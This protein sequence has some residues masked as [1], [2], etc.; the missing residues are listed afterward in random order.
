V[1]LA[2]NSNSTSGNGVNVNAVDLGAAFLPQNQ[3]PT[4][5]PN[6]TPGADALPANVLRPIQGYGA[7]YIYEQ[8]GWSTFHSMQTSFQRRYAK[9]LTAVFNW[10]W[11]LS[12]T[13]TTGLTQPYLQ[14]N[15]DGTWST[16]PLWNQY[17]ALN[18]NL[19]PA[20]HQIKANLIW[21]PAPVSLGSSARARTAAFV[22]N[23]WQISAVETA[24]TGAGYS[25]GYSYQNGGSNVNLTGS[26][27][28][29]AAIRIV[30]NPGSGCASNQYQ[31]F[32]VAAFAGPVAPSNGLESGR[33]P[34]RG[35]PWYFTDLA[36]A[37]NFNIGRSDRIRAQLRFD[38]FNAF[39]T[40]IYSSVNS[41]VQYD[42]PATQNVV[43]PQYVNGAILPA[44]LQ[45][46]NAG[47]GAVTGAYP[48][49]TSQLELRLFF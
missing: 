40:T 6:T 49:R 35:C 1:L 7:I 26:P 4:L 24:A 27:D 8:A 21:T 44:R 34:L 48:N 2:G 22:V 18:Q 41:T 14:H 47:F 37:R 16:S 36:L 29:A 31:Q 43:N 12:N 19:K 23:H 15:A 46:A 39:N 17:V 32:N 11:V 45:P 20:V 3:D 42:A 28:Y 13:G 25:V 5:A 33:N 30:G 9:Q 38:A 10:T